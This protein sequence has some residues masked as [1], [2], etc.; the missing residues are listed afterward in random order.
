MFRVF[1]SAHD[2]SSQLRRSSTVSARI[3]S[4]SELYGGCMLDRP[5]VVRPQ[6]ASVART[7]RIQ[8]SDGEREPDRCGA[9]RWT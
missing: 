9:D 6:S 1:Y 7:A 2:R 3:G 5:S 4:R 8:P